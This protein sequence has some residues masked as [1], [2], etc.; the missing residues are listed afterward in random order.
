MAWVVDSVVLENGG[1]GPKVGSAS[2]SF[3][4]AY[5]TETFKT[6]I[7][8]PLVKGTGAQQL[9]ALVAKADADKTAWVTLRTAEDALIPTI[10]NALNA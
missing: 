4:D 9:A 8:F 7:R 3:A 10:E 2:L 6:S 1:V 5:E